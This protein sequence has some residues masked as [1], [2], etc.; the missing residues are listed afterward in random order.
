MEQYR[1]KDE[2]LYC[3]LKKCLSGALKFHIMGATNQNHNQVKPQLDL[4]QDLGWIDVTVV[5]GNKIYKTTKKGEIA[6]KSYESYLDQVPPE[7]LHIF[8]S[9][10]TIT[11]FYKPTN[12]W[13]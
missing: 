7:L 10:R 11:Q 9:E 5:G 13:Y 1:K 2:R 4:L 8:I 12:K 6:I 3:V